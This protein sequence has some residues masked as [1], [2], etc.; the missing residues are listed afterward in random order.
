MRISIIT[1]F[2]VSFVCSV[3]LIFEELFIYPKIAMWV[4]DINVDDRISSFSMSVLGLAGLVLG[5]AVF[6]LILSLVGL[7][8]TVIPLLRKR[9]TES[10]LL[11]CSSLMA[12]I[13]SSLLCVFSFALIESHISVTHRMESYIEKKQQSEQVAA[14]DS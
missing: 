3:F 10:R 1:I 11:V 9:I 8:M 5:A 4:A 7:M 6:F 13:S 14:P 2:A 12:I